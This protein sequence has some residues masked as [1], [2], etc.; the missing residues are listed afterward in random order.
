VGEVVAEVWL[1][2]GSWAGFGLGVNGSA[3]FLGLSK[4]EALFSLGTNL[5][6]E[7]R[8]RGAASIALKSGTAAR[9]SCLL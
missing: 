5:R 2:A 9:L 6:D 1:D 3:G 8:F 7:P 4:I